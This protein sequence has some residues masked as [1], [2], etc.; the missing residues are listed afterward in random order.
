MFI[1]V[2]RFTVK[3]DLE[4]KFRERWR[5]FTECIRAERGSL[6]SRLH[7]TQKGELLAYAQWPSKESATRTGEYS[8][9]YKL[10]RKEMV[11][12][13]ASTEVL[14]ELHVLEDLLA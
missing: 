2:Y 9:R 12:C 14:Y 13:L 6:G 7:I 8:E 1:Y 4:E 11:D 3:P 10:A 5:A